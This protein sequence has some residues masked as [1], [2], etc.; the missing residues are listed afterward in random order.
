MNR[1]RPQRYHKLPD[2]PASDKVTDIGRP[3]YPP[4]MAV[5]LDGFTNR[6]LTTTLSTQ[7]TGGESL[8]LLPRNLRR[9]GLQI[10]NLDATGF[11]HYSFG[12]DLGENGFSLGPNGMALYD[13]TTPPDELYLFSTVNLRC[14]V[15]DVTRG[16][17]PPVATRK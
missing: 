8:R 5:Q 2:N 6:N 17:A 9:C 11:L 14:V 1:T 12:N 13:F 16:V 3:I 15:M 4:S 7:L 10:Q